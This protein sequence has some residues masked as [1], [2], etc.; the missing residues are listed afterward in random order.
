MVRTCFAPSPELI[1]RHRCLDPYYPNTHHPHY[2]QSAVQLRSWKTDALSWQ[3]RLQFVWNCRCARLSFVLRPFW[4]PPSCRLLLAGGFSFFL[5]FFFG[6]QARSLH[7][8]ALQDVACKL[9]AKLTIAIGA[10]G[11]YHIHINLHF[12]QSF[13]QIL[14]KLICCYH[15]E[16]GCFWWRKRVPGANS[17]GSQKDS[18][19]DFLGMHISN[20]PAMPS[21]IASIFGAVSGQLTTG[22][23]VKPPNF[24]ISIRFLA[25]VFPPMCSKFN[26]VS[27]GAGLPPHSC[28]KTIQNL[29]C[30]WLLKSQS[31]STELPLFLIF[32]YF[33]GSCLAKLFIMHLEAIAIMCGNCF[34]LECL[35]KILSW[36]VWYFPPLISALGDKKKVKKLVAISWG[37]WETKTIDVTQWVKFA[38]KN[39][40]QLLQWRRML[41]AFI[42]N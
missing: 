40:N 3:A 33:S 16:A 37:E 2:P 1:P 34:P 15:T 28:A 27:L 8:N 20:A 26:C 42:Y 19:K 21:P 13:V 35:A 38:I 36:N 32:P 18:R 10:T 6:Q 11:I 23:T 29:S 24:P 14:R 39:I 22:P 4:P 9:N 5:L 31:T 30:E 25:L 7:G 12:P 17:S 41:N